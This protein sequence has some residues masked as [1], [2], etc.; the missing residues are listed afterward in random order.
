MLSHI[1]LALLIQLAVARI[2][3]SWLGGAAAASTWGISREIA[4]A[5]YRWIEQFGSGLRDNMP[6]WGTFDP[7]VWHLDAMLDWALPCL[8][9]LTVWAWVRRRDRKRAAI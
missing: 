1:L 9:T 2:T 6:W 4:Q 8:A 5:E 3:R 7:R